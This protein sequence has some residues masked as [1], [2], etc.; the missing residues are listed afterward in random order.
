MYLCDRYTG[1]FIREIGMPKELI[2]GQHDEPAGVQFDAD[3]CILVGQSTIC[4]T[5]S[6]DVRRN[7]DF[8]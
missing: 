3:G 8:S 2:G 1:E 6:I 5:P 7:I 4:N